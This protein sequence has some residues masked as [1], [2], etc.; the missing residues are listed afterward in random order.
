MNQVRRDEWSPV[1][2]VQQPAGESR[3]EVYEFRLPRGEWRQVAERQRENIIFFQH[4][5]IL[6][7]MGVVVF[8]QD[9]DNRHH[10]IG[11]FIWKDGN[12]Y[13]FFK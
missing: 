13:K 12:H 5:Q 4:V 3:R 11:N 7:P 10:R 9:A 1:L 8:C 6:F 2:E